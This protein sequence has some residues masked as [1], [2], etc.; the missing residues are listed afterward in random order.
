MKL[1]SCV[2]C[3]TPHGSARTAQRRATPHA[4]PRHTDTQTHAQTGDARAIGIRIRHPTD[5]QRTGGPDPPSSLHRAC[6]A[7]QS[8]PL[9]GMESAAAPRGAPYGH[10][11]HF[12]ATEAKRRPRPRPEAARSAC[13]PRAARLTVTGPFTPRGRLPAKIASRAVNTHS[14]RDVR[15]SIV[16]GV[17]SSARHARDGRVRRNWRPRRKRGLKTSPYE[18]PL[19]FLWL[20]ANIGS[21]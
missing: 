13:S 1:E 20:R 21:Y 17:R 15:T 12:C 8:A 9:H 4:T 10:R 7:R 18:P 5:G 6:S 3:K 2:S 14:E 11:P 16:S 19:Q